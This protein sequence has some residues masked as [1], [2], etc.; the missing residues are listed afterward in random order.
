MSDSMTIVELAEL[1]E[2]ERLAYKAHDAEM[3][4]LRAP[5]EWLKARAKERLPLILRAL[6]PWGVDVQL[7]PTRSTTHNPGYTEPRDWSPDRPVFRATVAYFD[8]ETGQRHVVGL[9]IP[10]EL[11]LCSDADFAG[12]LEEAREAKLREHDEHKRA[13]LQNNRAVYL[14]RQRRA[15]LEAVDE[16]AKTLARGCRDAAT[17]E[18]LVRA[19]VDALAKRRKDEP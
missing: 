18:E 2:Q 13:V 12:Y 11:V 7:D 1:H 10:D 9:P 5:V 4:R 19:F 8:P 16:A 15:L 17:N 14:S 3:R 6:V